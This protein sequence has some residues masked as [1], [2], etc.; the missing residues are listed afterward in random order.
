MDIEKDYKTYLSHTS[1]NWDEIE[2]S[3]LCGCLNCGN[4]YPTEI[5]E[6]CFGDMNSEEL[7][8]ICTFCHETFLVGDASGLKITEELFNKLK[9]LR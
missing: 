3:H 8:A 9:G 2:Q 7:T 6:E 4:V 5:V 1:K